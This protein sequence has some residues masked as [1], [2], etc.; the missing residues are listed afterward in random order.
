MMSRV[1]IRTGTPL[2]RFL[3]P[4]NMVQLYLRLRAFKSETLIAYWLTWRDATTGVS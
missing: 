2:N 4:R 1:R 3:V